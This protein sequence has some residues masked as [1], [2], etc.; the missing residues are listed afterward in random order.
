M[1]DKWWNRDLIGNADPQ[2]TSR[3]GLVLQEV[4]QGMPPKSPKEAVED[5]RRRRIEVV[6]EHQGQ[7]QEVAA[8]KERRK[9][10]EELRKR[11]ETNVAI[12]TQV[13]L[14][15]FSAGCRTRCDIFNSL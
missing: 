13:K 15:R 12:A 11:R 1:I 9:I 8:G 14:G 10:Q 7:S 6:Q 2:P 3:N 4:Q 5:A